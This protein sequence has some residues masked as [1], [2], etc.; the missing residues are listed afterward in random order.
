[1]LTEQQL[2]DSGR[3]FKVGKFPFS[4][5]GRARTAGE[6]S[7]FVKIIA[8]AETDAIL[9]AHLIGP[10]VSELVS[11][12]VLAMEFDGSSEDVG[13]MIH[14]HPTLSEAVKEAA[15]GVLGRSI[16]I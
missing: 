3:A 16:H 8:D 4:A 10:A 14:G 9:G 2:A 12:L 5:N 13:I 1:G 15:L 7:G 6:T 11:E